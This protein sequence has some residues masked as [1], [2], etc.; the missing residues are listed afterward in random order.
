M[1]DFRLVA[2]T[3]DYQGCDTLMF[4]S[5]Q[6][7]ISAE[8][9]DPEWK[10][11]PTIAIGG[12][13]ASQIEKLGGTVLY[14]PTEFYG[15]ELA[16]DILARFL[17]RNVLYLRP[18]TVSFDSRTFLHHAGYE[19]KEQILYE[20]FC[21]FHS[22]EATP[23]SGSIIIFTSPSTIHCFLKRFDW[24]ATY[25]AIIIGTAT[26]EHLPPQCD[27]R[28]ADQPLINACIAKAL[29]VRNLR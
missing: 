29:E 4:T 18:R 22:A 12:A 26:L 13:T 25:T 1:I 24:D 7:V 11:R 28:V 10:K 23:P 27:Y 14:H 15:K 2:E 17:K 19:L 21:Q 6:A 9:I 5:K 8:A 16:K 20:T 3:I